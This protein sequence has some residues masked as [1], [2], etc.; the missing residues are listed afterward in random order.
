LS[1]RNAHRTAYN[2]GLVV[3][4]PVVRRYT[5][6]MAK[7]PKKTEPVTVRLDQDVRDDLEELARGLE[8]SLSWTINRGLRLWLD[9]KGLDRARLTRTLD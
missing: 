9:G 1:R 6:A 2:T 4:R 3:R 5:L 8:R 7:R